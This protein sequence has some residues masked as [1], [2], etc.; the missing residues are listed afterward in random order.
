MGSPL[1]GPDGIKKLDLMIDIPTTAT[2]L[3]Q[4]FRASLK[5]GRLPAQWKLAHVTPIYK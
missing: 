5:C 1:P 3:S 4:I 2:C